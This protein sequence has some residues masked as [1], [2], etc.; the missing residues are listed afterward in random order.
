MPELTLSDYSRILLQPDQ[1]KL[2]IFSVTAK[3]N[4]RCKMCI[5]WDRLN[6]SKDE[7]K[8][9]EI[10]QICRKAGDVMGVI[11]TGGEPF[12]RQD[13]HDIA[14]FFAK[15]NKTRLI[16]MST[17]GYSPQHIAQT[18]QKMLV[19]CPGSIITVDLSIDGVGALH[20][21]IREVPGLFDR[22]METYTLLDQLRGSHKNLRIKANTVISK[23]N[24]DHIMAVV[25]FV[26]TNMRVEDHSLTMTAGK[27]KESDSKDFSVDQHGQYI[28]EFE[29][30]RSYKQTDLFERLFKGLRKE[31]REE[32]LHV[33]KTGKLTSPCRAIKNFLF[34]DE[35]GGVYPCGTI[36]DKLGDLRKEDYDLNRILRLPKRFE[37]DK[38]YQISTT[39][40]CDW[41]CGFLF[42]I[43]YDPRKYPRIAKSLLQSNG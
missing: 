15:Y 40:A 24:Q 43:I 36:K 19:Q 20:D 32:V 10:E 6:K 41:D 22:I 35:E 26:K 34:L 37:I 38:K 12:L 5:Y 33:R 1:L 14:A 13:L 39:C 9:N 25:E 21:K 3:C 31:I 27:P 42:N 17:S 18:T 4:A 28:N 23:Y 11:L 16:H 7:L 2:L 8:L 29:T 30:S